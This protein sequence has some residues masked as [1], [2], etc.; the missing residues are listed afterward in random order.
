MSFMP[1]H[2]SLQSTI[3]VVFCFEFVP[4]GEHMLTTQDG[5]PKQVLTC[6]CGTKSPE[7]NSYGL[8]YGDIHAQTDFMPVMSNTGRTTW[9]CNDCY[10]KAHLL[11]LEIHKMVKDKHLSFLNLLKPVVVR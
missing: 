3:N 6:T 11:A 1:R 8:T 10:Q 7:I 2:E 5:F 9:L 4:T